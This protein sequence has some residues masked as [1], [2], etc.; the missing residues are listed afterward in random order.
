VRIQTADGTLDP[1]AREL[2]SPGREI[3]HAAFG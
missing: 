2:P 3:E 1:S